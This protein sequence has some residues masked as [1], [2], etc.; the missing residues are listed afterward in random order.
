MPAYCI[1]MAFSSTC[2]RPYAPFPY[3]QGF[4]HTR[5]RWNAL[6]T[7]LHSRAMRCRV[8]LRH[9]RFSRPHCPQRRLFRLVRRFRYPPRPLRR[10]TIRPQTQESASPTPDACARMHEPPAVPRYTSHRQP[11]SRV[12]AIHPSRNATPRTRICRIPHGT[13]Y[14]TILFQYD[15]CNTP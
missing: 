9:A 4:R 15:E 14:A 1:P 2:L 6:R 12:P 10:Q 7:M 5:V 8:C 13:V 3:Q 11:D